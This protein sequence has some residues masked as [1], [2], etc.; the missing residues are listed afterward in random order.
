MLWIDKDGEKQKANAQ[1]WVRN[2]KTGKALNYPWVFSGSGFWTDE[3]SGQRYYHADAGDFICVSNFPTAMLDLPIK[4]SGET[5]G[6]LFEAFTENIP[7]LGTYVR[8][9]LIP[10]LEQQKKAQPEKEQ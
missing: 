8:L 1:Q 3:D 7:P 6:L 4:S 2:L 9:V 5:A 10:Q